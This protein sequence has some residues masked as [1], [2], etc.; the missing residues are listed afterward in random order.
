MSAV[1]RRVPCPRALPVSTCTA[2]HIN[3]S[4]SGFWLDCQSVSLPFV[5]KFCHKWQHLW[6][7]AHP[8]NMRALSPEYA[9]LIMCVP[10]HRNMRALSPEYACLITGICVLYHRN[11]RALSCASLIT[12]I[13]MPYHVCCLHYSP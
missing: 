11:M 9:C 10:Y 13:C 3:T 6:L 5:H 2:P 7:L 8:I 1:S 4:S 12:G